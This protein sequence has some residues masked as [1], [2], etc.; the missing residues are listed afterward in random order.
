[1]RAHLLVVLATVPLQLLLWVGHVPI[2]LEVL[3]DGKAEDMALGW[4]PKTEQ[5]RV[6]RELQ[7]AVS[8]LSGVFEGLTRAVQE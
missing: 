8:A 2:D 7:W 5:V 6:V 1:M 4:Q 3:A